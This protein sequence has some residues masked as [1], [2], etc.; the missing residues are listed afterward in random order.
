MLLHTLIFPNAG[1]FVLWK[2]FLLLQ[3]LGSPISWTHWWKRH[4]LLGEHTPIFS[5][6]LDLRYNICLQTLIM[7]F[8]SNLLQMEKNRGL[9]QKCKKQT[10]NHMTQTVFLNVTNHFILILNVLFMLL[11]LYRFWSEMALRGVWQLQ[12][13]IVSYLLIV[14]D[15]FISWN[16]IDW[17]YRW[18]RKNTLA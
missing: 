3:D 11:L 2:T 7:Y 12:K 6:L 1:S 10:K 14:D 4:H 16:E 18:F 5:S 13:L 17:T 8:L 15:L 9:T